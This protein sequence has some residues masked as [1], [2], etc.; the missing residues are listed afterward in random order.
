MNNQNKNPDKR[1]RSGERTVRN[2]LA[3]VEYW[4][5]WRYNE[6]CK[7]ITKKDLVLDC[8]MGVGY[9]SFILS[10][11][12]KEV[13]GIDDSKEA[14][15]YAKK[16]WMA[17]NIRHIQGDVLRMGDFRPDIIVAYEIIEHIKNDKEFISYI[18]DLSKKYIVISTPHKSVNLKRSR[19]HWLH[20]DKQM[21][22]ERFVDNNWKCIRYEEPI[23]GTGSK[24]CFAVYKRIQK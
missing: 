12:A 19:W 4:H 2:K 20:Y 24:A 5:L 10:K 3:N 14:V 21:L 8:G 22:N 6:A 7:Y 9:G 18:K 23:F 15:L 17:S 11:V 16:Y 13:I 1:L